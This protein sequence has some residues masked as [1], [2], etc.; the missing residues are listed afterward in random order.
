MRWTRRHGKNSGP[1]ICPGFDD[2]KFRVGNKEKRVMSGGAKLA[3][4]WRPEWKC[5]PFLLARLIYRG[6]REEKTRTDLAQRFVRG[7]I[8][9]HE[10]FQCFTRTTQTKK[11]TI[12]YTT[13]GLVFA[14]IETCLQLNAKVSPVTPQ[15]RRWCTYSPFFRGKLM[16]RNSLFSADSRV[17]AYHCRRRRLVLHSFAKGSAAAAPRS[18]LRFASSDFFLL[19]ICWRMSHHHFPG[20]EKLSDKLSR[21]DNQEKAWPLR[22]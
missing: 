13:G 18:R 19:L 2:G 16:Q 20:G 10:V 7:V 22:A 21:K 8:M 17:S 4:K 12:G 5:L 14:A 1:E 11:G 3:A 6:Q 9:S 15:T